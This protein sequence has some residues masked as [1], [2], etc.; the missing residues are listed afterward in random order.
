MQ[1]GT[2]TPSQAP[3]YFYVNPVSGQLSVSKGF[4]QDV[5]L[6]DSYRVGLAS[7]EYLHM[8]FEVHQVRLVA[9][10]LHSVEYFVNCPRQ[11]AFN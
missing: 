4:S 10:P 8:M 11:T 3:E 1:A 2:S 5:E 6:P 7:S 9:L